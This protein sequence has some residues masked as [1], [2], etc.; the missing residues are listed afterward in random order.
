[1]LRKYP[2]IKRINSSLRIRSYSTTKND[3]AITLYE[4]DQLSKLPFFEESN[5]ERDP[6]RTNKTY[7]RERKDYIRNKINAVKSV[8]GI[9]HNDLPY[10]SYNFDKSL[11]SMYDCIANAKSHGRLSVTK[12]MTKSWCELR[13]SYD[14]YS[15]LDKLVTRNISNGITFHKLL[16]DKL[17]IEN[18]ELQKFLKLQQMESFQKSIVYK[19]QDTM[20]RLISTFSRI[21]ESREILCHGYIKNKGLNEP[22]DGEFILDVNN[23]VENS[24]DD[25]ENIMLV[26]G[27]IDHLRW[28]P[29]T[30]TNSKF[31]LF[32]DIFDDINFTKDISKLISS[33]QTEIP[34]R[35]NNW[36][37]QIADVKTR[38]MFTIPNQTSVQRASKLQIMYYKKFLDILTLNPERTY[39]MLLLNAKKRDLDIDKPLE[40]LEII[41][42]MIKNPSIISDMRRLRDGETI[43]FKPFDND[44]QVIKPMFNEL[45]APYTSLPYDVNEKFQEFMIPWKRPVTLRYFAARLAQTYNLF[46]SLLSNDLLIEYYCRGKNFH[47]VPFKY[48][49]SLLKEH[50]ADRSG[51]LLG[52]RHVEPI[53]Q[54]LENFLTF[55][56][57]CEYQTICSWKHEGEQNLRTL[58]KE[59]TNLWQ[60]DNN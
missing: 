56:K 1:M 43:N 18:V 6:I 15:K 42:L 8:V 10:L 12:M 57:H 21:G 44:T 28:V 45:T 60:A 30:E 11:P 13:Y 26:S 16:E 33:L 25:S 9:N 54:T 49:E 22:Q 36:K 50:N 5:I 17:I 39:A 52:K 58:G 55:C 38:Q 23:F 4:K 31:D 19:W 48:N 20:E 3:P 29:N 2:S 14:V 37:L 34:K 59:L 40:P 24:K 32:D 46:Q 51:Y 7:T 35:L 47:N 41:A 53:D 27:I